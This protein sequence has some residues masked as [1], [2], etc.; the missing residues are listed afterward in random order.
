[1]IICAARFTAFRPVPQFLLGVQAGMVSGKP[2]Y[3]A[4]CRAEGDALEIVAGLDGIAFAFVDANRDVLAPCLELLASR[5]VPGGIV[6]ADNVISHA[7]EIPGLVEAVLVDPRFD[8]VV[9]PIGSGVLT[10]RRTS[11]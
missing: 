10:A 1:M 8:A 4:A 3:M 7:A 9:V 6:A 5:L 2:A 11:A